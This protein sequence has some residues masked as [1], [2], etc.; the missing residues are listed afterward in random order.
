MALPCFWDE[1]TVGIVFR[2][3]P[4]CLRCPELLST[5]LHQFVSTESST[6]VERIFGNHRDIWKS[7]QPQGDEQPQHQHQAGS[8]GG[9]RQ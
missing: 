2:G 1:G 6:V 5:S 4:T 9:S 3:C 8:A 7:E